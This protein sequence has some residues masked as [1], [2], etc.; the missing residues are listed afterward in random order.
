MENYTQGKRFE[1]VTKSLATKIK[2]RVFVPISGKNEANFQTINVILRV[3]GKADVVPFDGQMSKQEYIALVAEKLA[4]ANLIVFPDEFCATDFAK[5][6]F[7]NELVFAELEKLLFVRDGLAFGEGRGVL[8]L[9]ELGLLPSGVLSPAKTGETDEN[10]EISL[11]VSS[12]LSPWLTDCK[13]GERYLGRVAP[14]TELSNAFYG[15]E[16]TVAEWSKKGMIA[17]VDE[18]GRIDGLTSA[19]GRIFGKLSLQTKNIAVQDID[20]KIFQAGL[21]YYM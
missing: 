16:K 4:G 7:K 10:G 6:I 15:D 14:Q 21:R 12:N 18:G 3:G 17:L 11:A 19:D 20:A 9:Q 13:V 8:L 5:E 2:P 1:N